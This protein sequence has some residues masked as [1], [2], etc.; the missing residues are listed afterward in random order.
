MMIFKDNARN[1][2]SPS[3]YAN[4]RGSWK[5]TIAKSLSELVELGRTIDT[6]STYEGMEILDLRRWEGVEG[7]SGVN[8]ELCV[9]LTLRMRKADEKKSS[10]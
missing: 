9:G 7:G 1:P 10:R 4:S 2:L 8:G 5:P 3:V 6:T